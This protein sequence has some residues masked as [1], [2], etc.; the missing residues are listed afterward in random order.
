MNS[1]AGDRRQGG[2]WDARAAT[3]EHPAALDATQLTRQ[4]RG[5]YKALHESQVDICRH[6]LED[7]ELIDDIFVDD[8][9][10]LVAQA[11]RQPQ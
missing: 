10:Q 9:R 4:V 3:G 5:A 1:P 2:R 8:H 11:V 7:W 6:V